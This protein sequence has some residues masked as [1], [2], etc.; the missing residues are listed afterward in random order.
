VVAGAGADRVETR[1]GADQVVGLG[2]G[3]LALLG[4][5]NDVIQVSSAIRGGQVRGGR[6]INTLSVVA[7][8]S[9]SRLTF[10]TPKSLVFTAGGRFFIHD[11]KRYVV[12][13]VRSG[14]P[15]GSLRFFGGRSP[16][17]VQTLLNG[18]YRHLEIRPGGGADTVQLSTAL[19]RSAGALVAGG[20]GNDRV[21]G[22][23]RPDSLMG[24]LGRD[25]VDGREGRDRCVAE[26]EISCE[27]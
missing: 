25:R 2:R 4:L 9:T 16:Q 5:G 11:F 26:R 27:R 15:A 21:W 12:S 7:S 19:R 3:E 22:S 1:G 10:R 18:H 8:G 6:G 13:P 24:D 20:P 17:V 14:G 23:R